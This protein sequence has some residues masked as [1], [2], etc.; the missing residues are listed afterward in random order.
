M[1]VALVALLLALAGTGYAAFR[2]PDNSVGSKQLKTG[3]VTTKKLHNRAVTGAKL[4]LNG[5]TV[6]N[7]AHA[8]SADSAPLSTTLP[9]GRTLTGE[10]SAEGHTGTTTGTVSVVSAQSFA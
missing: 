3:A 2:L 6:P 9:R 7:A 5:V 4:N 1:I 8:K 10:W